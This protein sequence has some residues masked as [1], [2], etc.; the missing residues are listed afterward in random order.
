MYIP[1]E[2]FCNLYSSASVVRVVLKK[3]G[4]IACACEKKSTFW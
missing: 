4:Q 3:N 2:E 1:K